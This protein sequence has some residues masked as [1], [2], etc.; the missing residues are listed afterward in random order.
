MMMIKKLWV[1]YQWLSPG[2]ALLF[3]RIFHHIFILL[4]QH[5]NKPFKWLLLEPHIIIKKQ[6][7]T[8][9]LW[10]IASIFGKSKHFLKL[11]KYFIAKATNVFQW[12]SI[13][14]RWPCFF[15]FSDVWFLGTLTKSHNPGYHCLFFFWREN[16]FF[17]VEKQALTQ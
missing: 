8:L 6:F 1:C 9:Q 3:G 7:C 5:L 13:F 10:V 14:F 4:L 16:F 12:I 15:H 2:W 11:W 17:K